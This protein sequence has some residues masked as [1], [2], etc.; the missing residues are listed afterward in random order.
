MSQPIPLLQ[1]PTPEAE[2]ASS[3]INGQA[4]DLVDDY[5]LQ[6]SVEALAAL[7]QLDRSPTPETLT[8][9]REQA[10]ALTEQCRLVEDEL[11]RFLAPL[12]ER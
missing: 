2:T 12:G 6:T 3:T 4:A 1:L 9:L 7:P 10:D 11:A 5:A 8:A